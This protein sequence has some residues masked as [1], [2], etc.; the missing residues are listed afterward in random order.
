MK[1]FCKVIIEDGKNFITMPNG[2]KIPGQIMTRITQDN[3][4]SFEKLGQAFI[5]IWVEFDKDTK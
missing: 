3:I 2:E 1:E 4:Q 5:K